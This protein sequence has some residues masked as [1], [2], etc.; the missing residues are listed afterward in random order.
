[1]HNKIFVQ[2]NMVDKEMGDIEAAKSAKVEPDDKLFQKIQGTVWNKDQEIKK[3]FEKVLIS[4]QRL[5]A[6]KC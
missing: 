4:A 6:K 2:W 3:S 1:M 5:E